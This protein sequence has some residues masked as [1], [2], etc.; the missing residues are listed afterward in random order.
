V[1]TEEW[2]P[3]HY[4]TNY[5]LFEDGD[6][7]KIEVM[8]ANV[9]THNAE[10]YDKQGYRWGLPYTANVEHLIPIASEP[11]SVT[12]ETKST[13]APHGG[14][15]D[16]YD[17]DKGFCTANDIMEF[18]AS[19]RWLGDALHMKDIFKACFRWG[20]KEGTSKEYDAKKIIYSAARL[21]RQYSGQEEMRVY[22]QSLL[23]DKQFGGKS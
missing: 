5:H 3:T 13:T 7:T 12:E 23:D 21:L 9:D 15:S 14:P 11:L 16:Y 18:L 10:V 17:F 20:K 2:K 22:L 8:L 4:I 1:N 6:Q 19:D